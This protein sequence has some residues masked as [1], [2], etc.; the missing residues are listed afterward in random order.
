M[1]LLGLGAIQMAGLLFF[2]LIGII[3]TFFRWRSGGGGVLVLR[4]FVVRT[5]PSADIH[6]EIVG[7]AQGLIGFL[8]TLAKIS[9]ES[10]L[11]VRKTDATL[12][13]VGLMGRRHTFVPLTQAQGSRSGYERPF[14]LLLISIFFLLNSL[15]GVVMV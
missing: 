1:E 10:T 4:R 5:E 15:V 9:P 8:L 13:A 2:V 7:R 6:V 14:L 3:L 12:D 11:T